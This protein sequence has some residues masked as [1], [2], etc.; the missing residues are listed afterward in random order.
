MLIF[1]LSCVYNISPALRIW[2]WVDFGVDFNDIVDGP[3]TQVPTIIY[4]PHHTGQ[5]QLAVN[6]DK[7]SASKIV[8][9]SSEPSGPLWIGINWMDLLLTLSAKGFAITWIERRRE[10]FR[11]WIFT[12]STFV[13]IVEC[14]VHIFKSIFS[15]TIIII[16]KI[17]T[18]VTI[19][20]IIV[21]ISTVQILIIFKA[22]KFKMLS[23]CIGSPYCQRLRALQPPCCPLYPSAS[24]T[25]SPS[26]WP[27]QPLLPLTE[28][29]NWHFSNMAQAHMTAN[30]CFSMEKQRDVKR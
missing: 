24:S 27:K 21:I 6:L 29:K 17:I 28:L 5:M 16:L 20:K 9:T 25:S 19:L 2:V 12:D 15:I 22:G 8:Q 18:I 7:A 3:P 13:A 26:L 30:K 1:A 11:K 14:G 4:H 10:G 23:R